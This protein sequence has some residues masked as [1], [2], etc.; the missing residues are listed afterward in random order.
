MS[1]IIVH[2]AVCD[3]VVR[4][5]TA[6]VDIDSSTRKGLEGPTELLSLGAATRHA[7]RHSVRLLSAIR[8]NAGATPA[9]V[10]QLTFI[11]GWLTHRAADRQM[12]PVFRANPDPAGKSPKLCSVYQDAFV[13]SKLMVPAGRTPFDPDMWDLPLAAPGVEKDPSASEHV[14]GKW[15][16]SASSSNT[17]TPSA[18][19]DP[20]EHRNAALAEAQ[21]LITMMLQRALLSF[22]TLIP[23]DS[24]I[25]P[26]I[27]RVAGLVQVRRNDLDRY[28]KAVL[29]PDPR[30]VKKYIVD[31]GFYDDADPIIAGARA[32]QHDGR[33]MNRAKALSLSGG[34][35]YAQA[36]RTGLGYVLAADDFLAGRL[37]E[38]RLA[39]AL[40]IGK[41]GR[42]GV[43]V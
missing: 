36:T 22:H 9:R 21:R 35:H 10:D 39:E 32:V 20:E 31:T 41:L 15:A 1:E 42:D 6:C 40:D 11:L 13:F 26:W 7:D 34:S 24:D 5:A 37:D 8:E 19:S 33:T 16:L 14:F 38:K 27:D 3:D 4:L 17:E 25:E 2:T 43:A 29:D 12:K 30:L 28:V 23:D 18:D